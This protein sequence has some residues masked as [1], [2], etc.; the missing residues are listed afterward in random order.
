MSIF[1][2]EDSN[3]TKNSSV[4]ILIFKDIFFHP[5]EASQVRRFLTTDHL[6][7][8]SART[9]AHRVEDGPTELWGAAPAPGRQGSL[10]QTAPAAGGGH[11]R[12]GSGIATE[13]L[14]A[15]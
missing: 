5:Q 6:P 14:Q 4:I 10:S 7:A 3:L 1:K 12:L 8:V 2:D 9:A 13:G 11:S 15:A